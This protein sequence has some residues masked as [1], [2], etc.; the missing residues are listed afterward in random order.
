MFPPEYISVISF[1]SDTGEFPAA[2]QA[3]DCCYSSY[4]YIFVCLSAI[5]S[6]SRTFGW[7]FAK[8]LL[9]TRIVT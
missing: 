6:L 3:A 2:I 4:Q 8:F 5:V 1:A 7:T 9:Y